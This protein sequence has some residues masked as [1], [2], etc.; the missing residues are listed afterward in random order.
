[1]KTK[2]V[3]IDLF[4]FVGFIATLITSSVYSES[5]ELL[6]AGADVEAMYHWGTIHCIVGI[7]FTVL[8]LIHIIQNWAFIKLLFR[9][10]LFQKNKT[11]LLAVLTFVLVTFSFLY[12]IAGFNEQSLKLHH[13]IVKPFMLI[14][15][16]HII[17]KAKQFF[18]LLK[19]IKR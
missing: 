13:I 5:K 9:K 4:L 19:A 14:I 6:A 7:V 1:M 8:M 3:I 11:T 16:I 10:K 2:K 15:I 18:R 12:F 17:L